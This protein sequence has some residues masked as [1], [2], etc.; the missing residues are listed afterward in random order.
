MSIGSGLFASANWALTADLTP[1]GAGGRFFG[2]LALATGGGAAVAG[3]YGSVVDV[4]GYSPLFLVAALTFV[5]SAAILPRAA[6]I[7]R[8]AG[9]AA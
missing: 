5:G 7:A 9:A 4:Y 3:L 1:T 6:L 2:L 8:V